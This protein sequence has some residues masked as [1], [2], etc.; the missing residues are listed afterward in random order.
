M[1]KMLALETAFEREWIGDSSFCFLDGGQVSSKVESNKFD[2]FL[3]KY[4]C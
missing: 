1:E 4:C 2:R 3:L